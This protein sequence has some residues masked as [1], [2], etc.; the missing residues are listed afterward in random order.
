MASKVNNHHDHT[1]DL[2]TF[3]QVADRLNVAVLTIR[4]WGAPNSA[5]W[6]ATTRGVRIPAAWVDAATLARAVTKPQRTTFADP[7]ARPAIRRYP[8]VGHHGA[9]VYV[10]SFRE[11]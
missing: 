4:S 7:S 3:A 11:E 6:Y 10:R 2:L 8:R 9:L 5:R 1:P